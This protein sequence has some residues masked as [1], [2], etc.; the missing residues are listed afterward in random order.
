[1]WQAGLR[2]ESIHPEEEA[3]DDAEEEALASGASAE[4][5]ARVPFDEAARPMAVR[6]TVEL[7]L[8]VAI[9]KIDLELALNGLCRPDHRIT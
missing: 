8:S 7:T 5:L 9:D 6:L 1:M 2:E 3:R 4:F